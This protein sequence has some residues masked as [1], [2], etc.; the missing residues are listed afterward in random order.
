MPE[1]DTG[2]VLPNSNSIQD[3][4]WIKQASIEPVKG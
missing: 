4:G 1:W 2:F 3:Q